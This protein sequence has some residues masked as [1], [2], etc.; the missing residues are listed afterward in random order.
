MNPFSK[1]ISA[2]PKRGFRRGRNSVSNHNVS[3]EKAR[4]RKRQTRSLHKSSLLK[5]SCGS[6]QKKTKLKCCLL[7]VNGL[8]DSTLAD[9]KNVFASKSPDICVLLETKRRFEDEG[10]NLDIPGYEVSE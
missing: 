8:S 7:N 1:G 4:Q 9:V 5:E 6:I 10:M 3:F 2:P